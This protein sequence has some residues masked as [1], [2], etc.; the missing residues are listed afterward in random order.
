M[1]PDVNRWSKGKV[2]AAIVVAGTMI[3]AAALHGPPQPSPAEAQPAPQQ[4]APGS[5]T[6][7]PAPRKPTTRE[8]IG[9]D[10]LEEKLGRESP[11]GEGVVAAHVEGGGMACL[12]DLKA[13]YLAE[14]ATI[15]RGGASG[16]SGHA[17]ATA[18]VIYGTR[19]MAPGIRK[20]YF[21]SSSDFLGKECLK[22]GTGEPPDPQ[23][24]RLSSHSWI[25]E[26]GGG[27]DALRRIDYL[28]DKYDALFVVGVNNGSDSKVPLLL[29]SAYNV[30]SV[31]N[32]VGASS[33]GY[34]RAEGAGRCKPEIVA[35]GGLTSFATPVVTAAAARLMEAA[36]QMKEEP[37]AKRVEV[38]KAV[39]MAGAE[40]PATW[41]RAAGK[42]LDEHLGAGRLRIDTSYA[43]LAA[44]RSHPGAVKQRYGWAHEG[45]TPMQSQAYTF[46]SHRPLGEASIM[47]VW[48]RKIDGR[49]IFD[50]KSRRGVWINTPRLGDFN[51]RLYCTDS[52]GNESLVAESA[53]TQDNLEHIHLNE[54]RPGRYRIEVIRGDNLPE[55]WE[56]ALAWRIENEPRKAESRDAGIANTASK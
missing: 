25:G 20:A 45:M 42:P 3:G 9:L 33:G 24:I 47:L 51:L 22:T 28:A 38:L 39:I 2:A 11:I 46:T 48:N 12:P 6:T 53:G 35:P 14:V 49:T 23:D 40:K 19:G 43:V 27:E 37:S 50:A 31:G 29:A 41:K 26:A 21:M 1:R 17:N 55:S 5:P 15:V 54:L 32:Y 4:D 18:A 34:T 16:Y 13:P 52:A 10:R 30:I 8:L 7:A 56:Y 36:D 44:G